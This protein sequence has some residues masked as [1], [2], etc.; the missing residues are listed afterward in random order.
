MTA[1]SGS[2]PAAWTGP[3]GVGPYLSALHRR[4]LA[5]PSGPAWR[6]SDASLVFADVSGFT[7]LAERLARQGKV[8][9]EELTDILSS[10]FTEL[11][12]VAARYG[13]DCLK[14]GGDAL[15]LHFDQPGHPRRAAAA[16]DA[17]Q[18]A[19]AALRRQRSSA[20]VVRLGIS[21]GVHTGP[22]LAFLVGESHRELVLVGPAVSRTLALEAA[23]GAGEVLVSD[24]TAAGLDLDDVE[25]GPAGLR[26]R[27]APAAAA[28]RRSAVADGADPALGIPEVLRPHLDGVRR[29]G[30][31]RLA[32]VAFVKFAGTDELLEAGG[33]QAVADALHELVVVVQRACAEHGA[34]FVGTDVDLG[35]GK[36][37]LASGVPS[38]SPDD[39]DR[40]LLVGRAVVEE[41]AG[42][43]LSVRVGVHRGRVFA[44]DLGSP[45]RRT[46]TVMGDAVNLAARVMGRAEPGQVVATQDVLDRR[47]S[48][49]DLEA[50][51]PFT[52]KGKSEPVVAQV[53]GAALGRS[54]VAEGDRT[55][56]IG[57]HHE[58]AM[59]REAFAAAHE[60][61]GRILEL[62]GEPGIGKSKLV[63]EISALDPDL[64]VLA[65]EA[66]RYS[67]ATPYFALRRGLRAALGMTID[68]PAAEVEA[69]LRE[70]IEASAPH[71]VPWTPLLGVPLGLELAD[72]AQTVALDPAARR[73]TLHTAV[74]DLMTAALDG[75]TLLTIEDA[76]W[77]DAASCELLLALFAH[78]E[79]RPWAVLVTRRPVE[80]G[81]DLSDTPSVTRLPLAPLDH[82][83]LVDLAGLTAGDAP[84]PPGALEE[85][86][87]RSGGNPLFLQELVVAAGRGSIA[88]LPDSVEAVVA[89]TI[90]TL[91]AADRTL[92]RHAAVLG[93]HVPL[94]VLG[95][96]LDADAA[97]L[98]AGVRR[99]SHFLVSQGGTARFRHILLRDVA[100]E[101]LSYRARR[102]LHDRAGTI[103]E[104][105]SATPDQV[106]ELLAIHF[107]RAGRFP[108]SWRYARIAADRAMRNGASVEAAGFYETALEAARR[109]EEIG[110]V[111]RAEVAEALGDAGD[112]S[113]RFERSA[114]AYLHARRLRVDGAERARICRKL[115]YLR[116]RQGRYG[117]AQRWFRRGL[118]EAARVDD[119][120]LA[121]RLW[122]ELT[123]ATVSSRVRQGRHAKS[124]PLQEAAIKAAKESGDRA[125]LANAYWVYDQLLVDQ[126]RYGEA[127]HSALAAEIY[128]DLGDHKGAASAYNEMGTTAYW[129]GRW[130]DA[131]A[132]YERAIESDQKAGAIVYNAIYLNNIGEIRSD[133]GRWDQAS[134]LL[135]EAYDLWTGGGWRIGSGW[136]LSNLG[137][138][139]ARQGRFD[140]S[141][142]QLDR[143]RAIFEDIGAEALLLET[144][145]RRM[146]LAVLVGDHATALG[147]ADPLAERARRVPLVNVAIL[148]QRLQGYA[149]AQAGHPD[150]G[151]E[152]LESCLASCRKSEAE[153]EAALTMEAMRRVGGLFGRRDLDGLAVETTATFERLGV[154]AT[155]PVP[156]T[157]A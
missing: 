113:G 98:R 93:G 58:V 119:P 69:A 36:V 139:S 134:R 140:S 129:L 61:D 38:A 85:L 108:A 141:E 110:P 121:S 55:P 89:S 130:D 68:T 111:E 154:V 118:A 16:A 146:E 56:L 67:L 127:T 86:V 81:L 83:A 133:Q 152:H 142:E 100:Y 12:E 62:T 64:S 17:M 73:S 57:R 11:L 155:P 24:A 122:A 115:G 22:V 137:R 156:L 131:V 126:G 65:F 53:V 120:A 40:L 48:E 46:F 60:G 97:E 47:R 51:E 132:C 44:V 19:L 123:T 80:G 72:T 5:E 104:S 26:L 94:S 90:D 63:A 138:L 31:H 25:E 84:L 21:M 112:L 7:Q 101:G 96:M 23:A 149:W 35:G 109:V 52:V 13:G 82:A 87:E 144:E 27:R 150:V 135:Q 14:F 33:P 4:W 71:L 18:G 157:T 78:I 34:T 37:I 153:Y 10:V 20:G 50:L 106:A 91:P 79:R 30:E 2:R 88:E 54:R 32:T 59:A 92:L 3:A 125:A 151:W 70:I 76:H 128:E 102:D 15:L 136:A 42:G 114:A 49:F 95:A 41:T 43:R 148:V 39:E 107:H 145:A 143:S 1:R 116:D 77:L 8:G 74:I 66:G 147:M 103:I 45:A 29:D 99:L 6:S 124:G 105:A 28:L 9:A 75:P 117:T